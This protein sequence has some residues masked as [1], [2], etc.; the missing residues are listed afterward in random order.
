MQS[1][2]SS[3]IKLTAY[4]CI[5]W[6]FHK[7]LHSL[8]ISGKMLYMFRVVSPPIIRSTYNCTYS[9][10]YL[11]N[12]YCYLPLLWMSWNWFECDVGIVLI[13]FGAVAT[14]QKQIKNT[15]QVP[16]TANTVVCVL[17]MRGDTTRNMQ[18]S[19]PEIN[20]L[21]N[22]ASCWKYIKRNIAG[23]VKVRLST[24]LLNSKRR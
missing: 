11:L 1:E 3:G 13:C 23:Y 12:R 2:P 10:W 9:I 5:C 4:S 15:Q 6:L 18:S 16:D 21:C 17:M 7:K 22:V 14:A 19:F 8:F 24:N 20:K